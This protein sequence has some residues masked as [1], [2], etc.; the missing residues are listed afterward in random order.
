MLAP[1]AVSLQMQA[2]ERP[3]AVAPAP[4]NAAVRDYVQSMPVESPMPDYPSTLVAI[5]GFPPDDSA[6]VSPVD[7]NSMLYPAPREP[8]SLD[9]SVAEQELGLVN[10]INRERQIRG[11]LPVDYDPLLASIARSHSEDM[12]V[13]NY[14]AHTAPGPE[15]STPMD[16]YLAAVSQRPQYAMVGENIYYRSATDSPDDYA[17]EANTAFMNSPGH[18]ANILMQAYTRVGV[19]IYVDPV[20]GAFWVTEMF[21]R[22][23]H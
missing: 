20:T 15:P 16:R 13:R 11:E 2:V 19:G 6:P 7:P 14:F 1:A 8:R 4:V 3:A 22:D 5:T 17:A 18:R 9:G 12:C 23:H 10:L 21:L